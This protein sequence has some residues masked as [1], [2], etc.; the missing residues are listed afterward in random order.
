MS[1]T[2]TLLSAGLLGVTLSAGLLA[3]SAAQAATS[4]HWEGYGYNRH[5]VCVQPVY[6]PKKPAPTG[7]YSDYRTPAPL[8]AYRPVDVK[9]TYSKDPYSKDPVKY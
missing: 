9:N 5:Q 7:Y 6:E 2:I 3:T 1:K 4:C 8:P